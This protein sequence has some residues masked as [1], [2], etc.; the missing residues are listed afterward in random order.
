MAD[1]WTRIRGLSGSGV[2]SVNLVVQAEGFA[3]QVRMIELLHP[4]NTAAFTLSVGRVFRGRVL[5]GAGQPMA[6]AVAQTDFDH[7]GLRKYE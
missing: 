1:D 6:G 3:P 2:P 5:D 7:Q 4:T